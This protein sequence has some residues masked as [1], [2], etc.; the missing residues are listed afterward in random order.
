V[1][2]DRV[3]GTGYSERL[4]EILIASLQQ[5]AIAGDVEGACRLAGQAYAATR[6]T[7]SHAE[8]RFNALLHRLCRR[9]R[10]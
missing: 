4:V 7:N 10:D 1:A 9:S 8:H 2:T 6:L 5:L 3:G